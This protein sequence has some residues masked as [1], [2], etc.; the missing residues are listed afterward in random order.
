MKILNHIRH[1][2]LICSYMPYMVQKIYHLKIYT[3][4]N[5][6]INGLIN[7]EE[8]SGL[9]FG[10]KYYFNQYNPQIIKLYAGILIG[11]NYNY[12][13]FLIPVGINI[14]LKKGFDLK[15]GV[16]GMNYFTYN[17]TYGELL[18]GWRF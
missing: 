10:P 2:M 14:A 1:I 12:F 7:A 3:T 8:G 17:N 6:E 15:L 16:V 13:N 5:F 11:T 9:A 4:I 18:I